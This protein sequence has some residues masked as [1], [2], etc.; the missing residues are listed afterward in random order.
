MFGKLID[1]VFRS[2]PSVITIDNR[3]IANPTDDMLISQGYKTVEETEMPVQ[4]GYDPRPVYTE[5][6]DRI[7]KTWELVERIVQ[8]DPMEE[9]VQIIYGL[10][11]EGE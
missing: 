9:F 5:E 4:D 8:T 7:V 3:V 1:G 11:T 2:A 6:E 10:K